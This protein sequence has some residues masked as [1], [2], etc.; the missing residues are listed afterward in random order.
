MVK[1]DLICILN[2]GLG[3]QLF[4]V[5]HAYTLEKKYGVTPIYDMGEYLFVTKYRKPDIYRLKI[6]EQMTFKSFDKR[7]RSWWRHQY[8]NEF[9]YKFFKKNI[10][11]EEKYRNKNYHW[12]T[13]EESDYFDEKSE[14]NVILGYFQREKFFISA[15]D[16]LQQLLIPRDDLIDQQTREYEKKMRSEQS[17][18]IHVR[19][20]DFV[21]LGIG[22]SMEYY[23]K[24]IALIKKKLSGDIK[25]YIF[26]ND[27]NWCKTQ[28][29]DLDCEYVSL[30]GKDA[31]INEMYLMS[32][33]KHNITSNSTFGWWGAWLNGNPD[34][35][36][37]AP[38]VGISQGV[39]PDSW[40]KI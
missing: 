35:I 8:V 7:L 19:R 29:S 26:S 15:R 38:T 25:F 27:I 30:Q 37:I 21:D 3:N 36:V 28:F 23:H 22:L 32:C 6:S 39:L 17:V 10:F 31:D 4:Q 1:K 12:I 34:K 20:G 18:S 16:D 11:K 2:G 9:A 24:A 33:C 5:A 13:G 40:I 14:L